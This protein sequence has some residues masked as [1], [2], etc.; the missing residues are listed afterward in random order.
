MLLVDDFTGEEDI[1][2]KV[3]LLSMKLKLRYLEGRFDLRKC[4]TNDKD[5]RELFRDGMVIVTALLKL[6]MFRGS[7]GMKS[8]LFTSLI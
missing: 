2:E 5:L 7:N 4:R 1:V 8:V 6:Q 3:Y